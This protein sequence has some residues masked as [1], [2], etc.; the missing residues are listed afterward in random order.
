[1]KI[2]REMALGGVALLGLT[3]FTVLIQ[4]SGFSLPGSSPPEIRY[5]SCFSGTVAVEL[6][7][8]SGRNGVYCVPR[9]IPVRAFLDL[10]GVLRE[11]AG[12]TLPG[13]SILDRPATVSVFRTA[14]RVETRPMDAAKRLALGIPIDVNRSNREE[15]VLVPGIG[16]VTAE[17]IL[18]RRSRAGSFRT[19]DDLL[20]VKGIGEKRFDKLRP[21]LCVGC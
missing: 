1:M 2:G 21:Y 7:G 5:A 17:R 11:A 14:G 15:L 3:A 9:G 20:Q 8:D 6:A 12:Q 16:E 10:A 13:T 4:S 18:D 19:L